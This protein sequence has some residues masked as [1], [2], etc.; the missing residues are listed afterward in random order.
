MIQNIK[1][2]FFNKKIKF[3][4]SKDRIVFPNAVR[5]WITK[6]ECKVCSLDNLNVEK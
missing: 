4:K 2:L 6:Q 5:L 3:F 1:K